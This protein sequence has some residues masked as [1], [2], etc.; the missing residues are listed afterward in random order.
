M[1]IEGPPGFQAQEKALGFSQHE[2]S[3]SSWVSRVP[4]LFMVVVAAPTLL[5]CVY[6]LFIAS[7]LYVSDA[8]FVVRSHSQEMTSPLTPVIQGFLGGGGGVTDAYEVQEYMVSRDA[9][10]DLERSQN[11][12]ALL[13]RPGGDFLARFPRP[14]ESRSFENLFRGYKRFVTVGLDPQTSISTL[15]VKAF[16]PQDARAV[17]NALLDGGEAL[18]NRLNVQAMTDAVRQATVQVEEARRQGEEAEA[19]LTDFRD[20]EKLIDPDR[21]S[22]VDLELLGRLEGQLISMRAERAGLAASAPESPQLP[23]LDR[24][25]AAF[26]TQLDAE[27]SRTAGQS[28]SL[29]PKVGE[30]ESLILERDIAAKSLEAAMATLETARIDARRQQLYLERVV[31]PNL[32]DKAE[33]PKKLK[34]IFTV[35]VTALVAYGVLSLFLAGLRE[36][37]QQ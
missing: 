20:R 9:V 3:P 22:Q 4:W 13:A 19:A 1:K 18:V 21:S 31:S 15:E 35:L 5:T 32:P 12:R 16:R 24:R 10:G 25:I 17:A 26:S 8:R 33:E 29:A 27:R 23:L 28:N 34:S 11:L 36:H 7:P 30:Y 6:Y 14:F 2:Q 37:R